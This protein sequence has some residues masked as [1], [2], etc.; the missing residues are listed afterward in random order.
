MLQ[1]LYT[2]KVNVLLKKSGTKVEHHGIKIEFIGQIGE[3]N[4]CKCIVNHWISI[5]IIII[6][7]IIICIIYY[8][9]T[10]L[11]TYLKDFISFQFPSDFLFTPFHVPLP[12]QHLFSNLLVG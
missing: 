6:L 1:M 12:S 5:I 10:Y 7:L 3:C 4:D 9:L 11:L 8:L 2:V